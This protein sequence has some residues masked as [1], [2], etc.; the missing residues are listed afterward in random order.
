MNLLSASFSL[1]HLRQLSLMS[2]SMGLL[3]LAPQVQA[4][5]SQ[6]LRKS[7]RPSRVLQLLHQPPRA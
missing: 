7:H 1:S 4:Q 3:A 5:F 2:V 6:D